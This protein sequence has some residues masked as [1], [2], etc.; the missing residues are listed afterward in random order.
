MEHPN[1]LTRDGAVEAP[2]SY[3]AADLLDDLIERAGQPPTSLTAT[4]HGSDPVF[5]ATFPMAELGAA[6]IGAAAAQ[7]ARLYELR[8]G[9][10]QTVDVD[11]DAAAAA[12]RAWRY[13]Q[14]VPARPDNGPHPV[15]FCR[16][17]DERWL[18]L[19]RMAPHHLDRILT[20]L[21]CTDDEAEI[22]R[23]V[24]SWE[25]AALEAAIMDAGACAALVRT[26]EEWAAHPQG[27]A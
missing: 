3:R 21:G 8:T 18:F 2:R 13:I 20:V 12:M 22:A 19:H 1:T 4:F 17:A 25:G 7:A 26:S 14:E 27:R 11:L 15:A 23:A 9:V 6:S 5:P 16:T 24:A 10:R